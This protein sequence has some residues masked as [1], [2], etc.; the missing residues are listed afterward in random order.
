MKKAQ[1]VSM[2]EKCLLLFF[3]FFFFFFI[4]CSLALCI[5]FRPHQSQFHRVSFTGAL[6]CTGGT[7]VESR[8][9]PGIYMYMC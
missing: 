9:V 8:N 2:T 5:R 6:R 7:F 3:L 1:I 4:L